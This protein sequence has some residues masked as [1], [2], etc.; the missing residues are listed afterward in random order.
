MKNT[1]APL[2]AWETGEIGRDEAHVRVAADD[3]GD[4][5]DNALG[6]QMISI[7]LQKQLIEELKLIAKY[8]GV[9]YQPLIRDVLSRFARAELRTIAVELQREQDAAQSVRQADREG[10]LQRPA[11]KRA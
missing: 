9:S 1:T 8:N 2:N 3:A 4:R 10:K 5:L 7:R 6:L 11:R